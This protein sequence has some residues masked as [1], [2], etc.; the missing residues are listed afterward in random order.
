MREWTDEEWRRA[1]DAARQ[2][3]VAGVMAW[4]LFQGT[5]WLVAYRICGC[6]P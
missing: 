2:V 4:A 6:A 5:G 3:V 1:A